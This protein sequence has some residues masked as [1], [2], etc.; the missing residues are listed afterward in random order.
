MRSPYA[1]GRSSTAPRLIA[2]LLAAAAVLAGCGGG[3]GSPGIGTRPDQ[4]G[5]QPTPPVNPNPP[6]NPNPPVGTPSPE[7]LNPNLLAAST[8]YANMCAKPRTGV[9]LFGRPFPDRQGTLLDELKFLRAWANE[10]YLWYNEIPNTYR[11]AEFT[12]ALDYFEVLKSPALTESGQP[13]DKYHFTYTTEE[14]D[15][16]QNSGIDLGYGVTWKRNSATAP[17]TWLVTLVEPGSPAAAAGLQRGDKLIKVDG[18]DFINGTDAA[19]VE[20]INA[21]LFPETAGTPHSFTL[22]RGSTTYDVTMTGADVVVDPVK[23]VQVFDTPTGKVG[24]L[25]FETHNA[26]SEKELVDAFAT[27]RAAG[28][29][30]LVL[31]MRYNGGGLLYVASELSYMIAGPAQTT[32][33]TFER[34]QYNDKTPQQAPIPFLSS[35]YGFSSPNPVRSGTPLPYLG[36]KRVSILTTPGTCSA[37]EAVINGLRGADVQVDVIGSQTCGKPYG[38]T[39]TAN[40]GTTY[41]SIEFKGVNHKGFGDFPDGLA[42]TCQ[43]AD[44]LSKPLGDRSE[45]L[46]AAALSYRETGTCPPATRARQVPMELVRHPAKEISIYTRPRN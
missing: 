16:L 19:T 4:T 22:Q 35:A 28:V 46:L 37:S 32:G 33:K 36:L 9:D 17:R 13:K 43:V 7:D 18:V 5:Q 14:W 40:C 15:K 27:F 2:A 38:F 11:M 20:K 3:G 12:N 44:D 21:G 23:L 45:G 1:H 42:A 29:V 24:Y 39:P 31:D 10:N 34:L 6:A 25:S 26:V 8:T 30:D 41:F